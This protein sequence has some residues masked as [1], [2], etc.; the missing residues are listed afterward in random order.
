MFSRAA[1][2]LLPLRTEE[3]APTPHFEAHNGAGGARTGGG[4]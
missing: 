3:A 4:G 1:A 2:A